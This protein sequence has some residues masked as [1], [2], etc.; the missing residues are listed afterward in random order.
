M[1][2]RGANIQKRLIALNFKRYYNEKVYWFIY[3]GEANHL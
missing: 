1:I 3:K 2:I